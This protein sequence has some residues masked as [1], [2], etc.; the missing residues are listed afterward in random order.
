MPRGRKQQDSSILEMALLGF[1]AKKQEIEERINALRAQL[2]V[3]RG[4]PP[5]RPAEDRT[6]P[7]KKRTLSAAARKRISAAQK[8]RWAEHRREQSGSE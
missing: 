7:R 8:R 3:R 4:R 6:A 1:E 5:G 2:G